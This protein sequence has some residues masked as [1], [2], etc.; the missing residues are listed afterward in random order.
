LVQA[1]LYEVRGIDTFVLLISVSTLAA[2][3][4]IAGFIPARRAASI[5]PASALRAE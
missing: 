4:F 3:A 2:A 5:H 1:Q